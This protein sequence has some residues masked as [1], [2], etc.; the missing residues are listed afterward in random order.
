[1]SAP[2]VALPDGTRVPALGQGTWHM[3]ENAAARAA[4]VRALR[5]GLDRGLTLIDTAEMYGAGGAEAVVGEAIAGRRDQVFLVSKVFPHNADGPRMAAACEASLQRLGVECLDLYLLHWPGRVPPQETIA[6]FERLRAAGKIRRWG[7]SNFDA[8]ELRTW[9]ALPGG[10]A[11]A[12]DQVLYHLGSRGIEHDLLPACRERG[13]PVMAYCPLG[14]GRG[15]LTDA[16]LARIAAG[17]GLTPAQ[18]MLAWTL[19]GGDTVAIPKAADTAH[20][21][22]NAAAAGLTLDDDT[23]AALDAAFP[24]PAGK[25]PLDIV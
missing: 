7:V 18:L 12:T 21:T 4:E 13:L 10:E 1:M 15:P 8:D 2:Q 22:D 11:C 16:R 14:Q 20:V 19:R 6:A 9:L 3:G 23:L 17:A 5:A 25:R 24:P